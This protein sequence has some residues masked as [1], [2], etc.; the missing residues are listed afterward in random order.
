[1]QALPCCVCP[2]LAAGAVVVKLGARP[3]QR[4][5]GVEGQGGLLVVAPQVCRARR[6]GQPGSDGLR[7]A[8]AAVP[9][10]SCCSTAAARLPPSCRSAA[11]QLPPTFQ[12]ELVHG[13]LLAHHLDLHGHPAATRVCVCVWGGGAQLMTSP[14]LLHSCT[15]ASTQNAW[16]IVRPCA[17]RTHPTHPTARTQSGHGHSLAQLLGGRVHKA[18]GRAIWVT[19]LQAAA[20]HT[21][22]WL[23]Q[24]GGSSGHRALAAGHTIRYPPKKQYHHTAEQ[25]L[26][27]PT[28][29]TKPSARCTSMPS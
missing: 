14:Q 2:H 24:A 19:S 8:A 1:M 5:V 21:K 12:V 7:P 9:P 20:P 17:V 23:T 22:A 11:A 15:A 18:V 3:C 10:P 16:M 6:S 13:L 28:C 25:H 26:P 4:A 29:T 27:P